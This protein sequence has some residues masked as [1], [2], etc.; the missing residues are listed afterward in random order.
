MSDINS[1]L[2]T[3]FFNDP[4]MI[5]IN[6]QQFKYSNLIKM[7]AHEIIKDLN[8][9]IYTN[10]NIKR[11]VDKFITL[12]FQVIDKDSK[13]IKSV[14]EIHNSYIVKFLTKT[15]DIFND[16][17]DIY[18]KH[19][20]LIHTDF[21]N[22]DSRRDDLK[23]YK[24]CC[25][26]L[27][28]LYLKGGVAI[29]Y[30]FYYI[31]F[32]IDKTVL[33]NDELTNNLG[34]F[35]DFD[36]N[37]IINYTLKPI[38]S[39]NNQIVG[40]DDIW[41]NIYLYVKETIIITLNKFVN[42]SDP[43]KTLNLSDTFKNE[44]Y[45]NIK[46]A[47]TDL[48]PNEKM[49]NVYS[50]TGMNVKSGGH[51]DYIFSNGPI[52]QI[53]L[54]SNNVVST[55]P[56]QDVV[57]VTS[58]FEIP[59]FILFRVVF[60]MGIAVN[61]SP[62]QYTFGELVDVSI[63][64]FYSTT[65]SG[66]IISENRMHKI[67]PELINDWEHCVKSFQVNVNQCNE[68]ICSKKESTNQEDD[69]YNVYIYDMD[70]MIHDL[71]VT[72]EETKARG[73]TSKV[74]KREKRLNFIKKYR[75]HYKQLIDYHSSIIG[76]TIDTTIPTY[77]LDQ[78]NEM[79]KYTYMNENISNYIWN[80]LSPPGVNMGHTPELFGY[81]LVINFIDKHS[82]DKYTGI[83]IIN[84]AFTKKTRFQEMSDLINATKK[85]IHSIYYTVGN[86]QMYNL[87]DNY[88]IL[89]GAFLSL[90][91]SYYHFTTSIN[92][93]FAQN[94][95]YY[96]FMLSIAKYNK[97]FIE[98]IENDTQ[99][100]V[101]QS[102]LFPYNV[103]N[104][105]LSSIFE[106]LLIKKIERLSIE[107]VKP[108][109]KQFIPLFFNLYHKKYVEL[110]KTTNDY[111]NDL[112]LAIRGGFAYNLL[113]NGLFDNNINT[114]NRNRTIKNATLTDM[115][116][117]KTLFQSM[118]DII[119]TNDLDLVL[120]SYTQ[121]NLVNDLKAWIKSILSVMP[122]ITNEGKTFIDSISEFVKKPVTLDI[123]ELSNELIQVLLSYPIE[124]E[125]AE[126][127][128]PGFQN[129]NIIC[130]HHIFELNLYSIAIPDEE[131]RPYMINILR[132]EGF[133]I[134]MPP[135]NDFIQPS[136]FIQSKEKML[137]EYK[138]IVSKEDKHWYRA[139]KYLGRIVN[140]LK[141]PEPKTIQTP[142]VTNIQMQ[143]YIPPT[144]APTNWNANVPTPL[145]LLEIEVAQRNAPYTTPITFGDFFPKP[146]TP[147]PGADND[148]YK[149]EG[150]TRYKTLRHIN[151][152]RKSNIKHNNKTKHNN[153]K[154]KHNNNKTKHNNNKTKH[155][156]NKTKPNTRAKRYKLRF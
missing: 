6:Q 14:N 61:N 136:V 110:K 54:N 92:D 102:I 143:T 129:F 153:N 37:F 65:K 36:M 100:S 30:A 12:Y 44:Y 21:T 86:N 116:D 42:S 87:T 78:I 99:Q 4:T 103:R 7:L 90:L 84:G 50:I 154:T 96:L 62:P 126:E 145:T 130:T 80:L 27:F 135:Y 73:E 144:P 24:I 156:N 60:G 56:V 134:I 31:N 20:L 106:T 141:P 49:F 72:L 59:E 88:K 69:F 75:C 94:Y 16:N 122:T 64:K 1:N 22:Y 8:K 11:E 15:Y 39:K 140:L 26:H 150:G 79:S 25:R 97:I 17:K 118:K 114:Y 127:I 68:N 19:Q 18:N 66:D 117:D 34:N 55:T 133:E 29:R 71:E 35:S 123:T 147:S 9:A 138:K 85:T 43:L 70:I 108:V 132:N 83:D 95:S 101:Q 67:N 48:N 155:N 77:C 104:N 51:F 128:L 115:F 58:N 23:L 10:A 82:I 76:G 63:L 113:L 152:S 89:N 81:N 2:T 52:A 33:T 124:T 40:M 53:N 121:G 125:N 45:S 119:D 109:V 131:P 93:N 3:R 57:L 32:L 91:A 120:F 46:N 139:N 38:D 148:F 13:K 151:K 107:I 74:A 98:A 41:E 47:L 149:V 146:P 105:A 142:T 28:K 5:T 111:S 112:Y 137:S